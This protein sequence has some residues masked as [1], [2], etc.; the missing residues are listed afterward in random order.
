MDASARTECLPSTRQDILQF[1]TDWVISPSSD[2]NILWIHGMAGAGKSALSTTISNYFQNLGRLAAFLFFDRD[3]TERSDPTSVIRTLAY[4]LGVFDSK[5]LNAISSAAWRFS[6]QWTLAAQCKRLLIEPLSS[7]EHVGDEG[8]FVIVIDAL[9][10]CGSAKTRKP[11]LDLLVEEFSKLSSNFRIIITSRAERDIQTSFGQRQNILSRELDVTTA[12][13]TKDILSYLHHWMAIIRANNPLLSLPPDWPGE[14]RTMDLAKRSSGLFVW[15]STAIVFIGDGHDPDERLMVLLSSDNQSKGE[16]ALD[17]LFITAL[18]SI[19]KW[20]DE[21]FRSD[22]H[23][24]MGAILAARDPL[25]PAAIDKLIKLTRPSLHTVSYLGCVLHWSTNYSAIR[26]LHPSFGEFLTDRARC[27]EDD[28]YIDLVHH[29]RQLGR[30]CLR[31]LE[32]ELHENVLGLKHDC[33]RPPEHSLLPED[34]GYA[35]TF[36]IDHVC[37]AEDEIPALVDESNQFINHHLLHWFEAMSIAG[38]VGM[39]TILLARLQ[40]WLKVCLFSISGTYL[41]TDFNA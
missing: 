41:L 24:I 39:T 1:V 40:A 34:I 26:I 9:D 16:A 27:G 29:N 14:S 13:N 2:Q 32:E 19:G 23:S 25:S 6:W 20:K 8:P 15:A 18:R 21:A 4:Q 38:R 10:E 30:H 37:T 3:I 31:H 5:I 17:D 33:R 28:W 11:L 35:S 36:W 22:F 7:I 12:S